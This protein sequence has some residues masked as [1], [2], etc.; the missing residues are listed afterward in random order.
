M[1]GNNGKIRFGQVSEMVFEESKGKYYL[2]VNCFKR[3]E[4]NDQR[5]SPFKDSQY[6]QAKMFYQE[7]G[8]DLIIEGDMVQ[9]HIATLSYSSKASGT[10]QDT[11]CAVAINFNVRFPIISKKI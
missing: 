8:P 5:R 10:Q 7:L 6:I 4:V 2:M 1:R 3:M 11:L 9:A